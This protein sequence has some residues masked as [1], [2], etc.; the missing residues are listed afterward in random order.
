[1][2]AKFSPLCS[3]WQLAHSFWLALT[4]PNEA[5]SPRLAAIRPP[6]SLWHSRHLKL[7]APA[8]SLWQLVH[9]V[10]PLRDWCARDSGPGEICA[11]LAAVNSQNKHEIT[12]R[13]GIA[14]DAQPA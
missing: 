12:S 11:Q 3:E 13:C 7:A 14:P 8:P 4:A 6:M 1:M 9:C 2:S 10:A 5:C